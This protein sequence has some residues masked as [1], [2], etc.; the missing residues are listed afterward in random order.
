MID[1]DFSALS[2]PSRRIGCSF[3]QAVAIVALLGA[4]VLIA[5]PAHAQPSAESGQYIDPAMGKPWACAKCRPWTPPPPPECCAKPPPTCCVAPPP[6]AVA[7]PVITPPPKPAEPPRPRKPKPPRKVH[8]PC[9]IITKTI[10]V[11]KPS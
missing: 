6:A 9:E 7:P 10:N 1:T 3:A 4:G 11:C 5:L 2:G 8:K